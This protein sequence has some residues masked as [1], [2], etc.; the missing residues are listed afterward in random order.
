M[1]R[2]AV[3]P[4]LKFCCPVIRLPSRTAKPFHSPAWMKLAPSALS[5][6]SM[7]HG[8]T[9][10]PGGEGAGV[11]HRLVGEVLLDIGEPGDGLA[12]DEG[13]TVRQPGVAQQADA[14]AQGGADPAGLVELGELGVQ[15]GGRLE[16]EHRALAAGDDDGVEP[17]RVDVVDGTGVLDELHELGVVLVPAA[18]HVLGLPA[19]GSSGSLI[20]SASHRPPWGLN[21]STS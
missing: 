3:S 12:G 16:G 8:M 6:S 17:F 5:S 15:V 7:R 19:A 1:T 21:S 14:V 4:P 13:L 2:S 20:A 18:D 9:W 11:P 10:V